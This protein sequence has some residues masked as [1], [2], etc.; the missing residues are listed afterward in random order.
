MD[1]DEASQIMFRKNFIDLS[2]KERR[3]IISKLG[4]PNDYRSKTNYPE[5][6]EKYRRND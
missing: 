3:V 2:Q 4:E 6:N 5:I 1:H